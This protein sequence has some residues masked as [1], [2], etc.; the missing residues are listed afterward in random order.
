MGTRKSSWEGSVSKDDA[1]GEILRTKTGV[2]RFCTRGE[3]DVFGGVY[4]VCTW[5][6]EEATIGYGDS[7]GGSFSFFS[8]YPRFV[9]IHRNKGGVLKLYRF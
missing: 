5:H 7:S 3:V 8:Q 9:Y 1:Y 6:G 4:A 2:E